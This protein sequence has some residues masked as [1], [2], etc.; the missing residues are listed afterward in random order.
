[1]DFE[2]VLTQVGDFGKFQ[3]VLVY[4]FLIPTSA[5]NIIYDY[6]FMLTTPEHYCRVLNISLEEQKHVIRP[7]TIEQ[8]LPTYDKC[9]MFD[10]N[11]DLYLNTTNFSLNDT[12]VLKIKECQNGW[13][14]ETD[15]FKETATTVVRHNDHAHCCS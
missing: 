7:M 13:I 3:S 15:V 11:Y 1:M 9:R 2:D 14:Y 5:L 8:G 12:S 10:L 6:M 4:L